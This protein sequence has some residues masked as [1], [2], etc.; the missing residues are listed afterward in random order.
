MRTEVK[1]GTAVMEFETDERC[2]ISEVAND[3]GDEQVSISRARVKPGSTTAW[4]RLKGVSERYI[5]A[6]GAGRVDLQG[7]E[8]TD[9]SAGDVVRIPADI[10]Q[11]ITN[12]GDTDLI[13]YCVCSPPFRQD[14]YETL[15]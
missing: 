10:P 11:R 9:V 2:F 6:S 13:F 1:K 4:H 7:L 14:C 5:I 8:T 12:M 15:E 3:L